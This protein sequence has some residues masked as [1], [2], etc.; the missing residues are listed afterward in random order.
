MTF[1]THSCKTIL[2]VRNANNKKWFRNSFDR[3]MDLYRKLYTPWSTVLLEK[4]TCPQLVKNFP[5]F[6]GTQTIITEFTSACHLSL[7]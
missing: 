7:S 6:D 5:A 4:L 2:S 3:G 1:H